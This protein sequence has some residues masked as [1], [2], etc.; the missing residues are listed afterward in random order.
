MSLLKD[1]WQKLFMSEGTIRPET[2][3]YVAVEGEDDENETNR[4]QRCLSHV[5]SYC[6]ESRR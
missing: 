6:T 3:F 1:G 2:M 4:A 5:S